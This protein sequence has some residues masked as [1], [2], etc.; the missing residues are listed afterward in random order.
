[1]TDRA[2]VARSLQGVQ[3]HLTQAGID[4]RIKQ[5]TRTQ[6][7]DGAPAI[8][9]AYERPLAVPPACDLWTENVGRNEERIPYPN[10]GCATQH[11][12]AVMVDNARDLQKPQ[13]EDPRASERRSVTWSVYVG[14][15]A[16]KGGGGDGDTAKQA[17]TPSPKK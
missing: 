4:Y 12:L 3:R 9:V 8:R 7:L 14:T 11:N 6:R 13:P 1:V 15:P 5:G 10:F 16:A 17:M 2:S